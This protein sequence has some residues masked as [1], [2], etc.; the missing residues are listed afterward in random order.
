MFMISQFGKRNKS[1]TMILVLL[2]SY[3][4]VHAQI[5]VTISGTIKD[6]KSGEVLYGA[7]LSVA[8]KKSIGVTANEYGFYSLSLPKGKYTFKVSYVSY[9]EEVQTISLDSNVVINW[10]LTDKKQLQEV[11]IST[12]KKDD[13]LRK[14]VMGTETLNMAEIA[15]IPVIFGE[16]DI[17]KTIQ[18][19]PGVKSNGEGSNGFTVRGGAT[20]QNLILLDEAPVYNASHLL[21]FF[22][23]FNSDAIKDAT[24]IKGNSPAQYG[25]RLSSVLDVKMKEGN[26]KE[27]NVTGGIGL[28]SSRLSVEGPIQKEKSS[29]I[30]SGRRTYADVFLKASPDFSDSKLYFY[31]LNAKANYRINEKNRIY[32]SG[33]FGRDVLGF[34]NTFNTDWGNSTATLRWNSILGSRFFSNTSLIYSNYDYNIRIKNNETDFNINSNIKDL[35]LKQDFSYYANPKNSLRF[36]FNIIHHTITPNRFSGTVNN[37]VAKQGRK[38]IE[39]AVYISNNYKPTDKLSFDYGLR[40]SAY[41]ILGGDTYNIYDKGIKTDSIILADGTTGKTYYNAEPRLTAN[42]RINDVS[43]IKAGYSR[44]TQN[45]HLMSNSTGG[46]PTDQWMGNSYNTKPEIADQLSIGYSRNFNDNNYE[47]NAEAYYKNMQSQVDY[48][49]GADI[50]TAAD[51]E[52]ELLYGKGRAY[53]L[54]LLL[55]KK[56]GRLTGWVGYT[57][58]KTERKIDGINNNDWYNAR[59]DRTHDVSLVGIYELNKRWT[60]SATFIYNT[61]N[62]VTFPTGKYNLNGLTVYQY[63][64]RNANRM[65]ANHRLDFGAT[66]ERKKNKRFQ[67]SWNFSLYNVYGRENTYTIT[68]R[69]NENDPTKTEAVKTSLFRWVPS[70][71]CNFKF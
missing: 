25:G 42:Y 53:G 26:N 59:Q 70:V 31:D 55:R 60:L 49:D 10:E 30:V 16:K 43:S 44:N 56:T 35:N 61:G 51:I 3:S 52:S 1:V 34:G 64:N 46:S 2:L 48:K 40:F 36:G 8:E 69:D 7:T 54:E 41:T 23:T 19:L 37:N 57:L 50:N 39:S 47:F 63:A 32:F 9:N 33:Y 11:V 15:K 45:L 38:S 22:S 6:K 29:F 4:V 65:P 67:S 18:L 13:N 24:I 28:I 20:D 14:P 66:Y 71:T 5:R 68:F 12:K 17:I 62:A 27:Y 21:G 58:S